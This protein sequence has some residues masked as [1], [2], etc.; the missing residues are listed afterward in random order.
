MK[1]KKAIL[2]TGAGSGIGKATAELF[3]RQG[4]RVGLLDINGLALQALSDQLD[5]CWYRQLNVTDADAVTAAIVSF[6]Q[7]HDN[8]LDCLFNSAGILY[9]GAFE[10]VALDD[11]HRTF[12][13]NVS[14]LMNCCYAAL[15][16]LKNAGN[17]VVL[18]MSS[19]SALYGVPQLASYS[20]SKFA[21]RG[22][23]EALN[24]EWQ[25]YGIQVCDLMPPFVN[26]PMVNEQARTPKVV[27]RLG[28]NLQAEDV[29]KAAWKALQDKQ[30]H[31]PVGLQFSALMNLSKL[32][33]SNFTRLIMSVLSR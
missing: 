27:Q 8:K 23:T 32:L 4:W 26:T 9:M 11:H 2:I 19:A 20:A 24:I 17:A 22:L 30:V 15:P 33:P 1:V 6:A 18:N 16:Y 10:D 14:G 13:V 5:N 12:D 29:A 21:V 25:P 28:V 3:H 7:V 31:H